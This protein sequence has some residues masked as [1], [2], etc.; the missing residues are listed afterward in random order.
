[1]RLAKRLSQAVRMI[2][3]FICWTTLHRMHISPRRAIGALWRTK[4]SLDCWVLP[5]DRAKK[6]SQWSNLVLMQ[7]FDLCIS[8]RETWGARKSWQG[9]WALTLLGIV[10]SALDLWKRGQMIPFEW[11]P[12]M[13]T[14]Y[15]CDSFLLVQF[16]IPISSHGYFRMWMLGCHMV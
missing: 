8:L 12:T 7:A 2:P 15:V 4:S 5:C 6:L 16:Y 13:Q 3:T 10:R 9:K 1:M 11:N 14:G